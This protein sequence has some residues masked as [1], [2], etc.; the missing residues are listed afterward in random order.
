MVLPL[1]VALWRT[2]DGGVPT[3]GTNTDSSNNNMLVLPS[4]S[5]GFKFRCI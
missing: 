4:Q 5:P 3:D 1:L 2:P